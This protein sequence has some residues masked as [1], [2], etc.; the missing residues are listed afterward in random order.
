IRMLIMHSTSLSDLQTLPLSGCPRHHNKCTVA[1]RITLCLSEIQRYL[2]TLVFPNL[3][4][5]EK[6]A[7]KAG[8]FP[9]SDAP[10]QAGQH[11]HC[12]HTPQAHRIR[13]GKS[14]TSRHRSAT[15]GTRRQC[16]WIHEH[17]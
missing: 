16:S 12:T 2:H 13:R 8:Q 4:P 15:T 5:E 17:I 6:A 1:A 7:W 11:M 14:A 9:Y 10:G 3:P